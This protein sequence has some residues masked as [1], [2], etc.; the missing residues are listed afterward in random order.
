M[1]SPGR[2]AESPVEEQALPTSFG[3]TMQ[4]DLSR[5]GQNPPGFTSTQ[6]TQL[7]SRYDDGDTL[8]KLMQHE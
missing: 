2:I 3:H 1:R 7:L 4:R 8:P 6:Q 5:H